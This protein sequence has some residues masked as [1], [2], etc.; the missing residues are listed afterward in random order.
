ML[1]FNLNR[2]E[3]CGMSNFI[4]GFWQLFPAGTITGV[5]T[6]IREQYHG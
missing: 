4:T 5:L 2:I 3:G 6:N 1:S